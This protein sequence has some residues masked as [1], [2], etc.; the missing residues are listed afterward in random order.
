MT[1]MKSFDVGDCVRIISD[2][3]EYRR[4][5]DSVLEVI[6]INT[7]TG[8][9]NECSGSVLYRCYDL[10][11]GEVLDFDLYDWQIEAVEE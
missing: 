6:A 11:L 8:Q 3:I 10:T 1:L 4:H 9:P 5:D 2:K 7:D